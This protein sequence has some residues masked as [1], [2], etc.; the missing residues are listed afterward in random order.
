MTVLFI[1]TCIKYFV[2]C[3]NRFVYLLIS[4]RY[5]HWS[6]LN[7]ALYFNK[8]IQL[9]YS[10]QHRHRCINNIHI[11]IHPM[12]YFCWVHFTNF[13]HE[14]FSQTTEGV[15]TKSSIQYAP[16]RPTPFMKLRYLAY[17]YVYLEVTIEC[18]QNT[19]VHKVYEVTRFM[20]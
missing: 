11:Q 15:K 18:L 7:H 5:A 20:L 4:C 14:I 12:I 6:C 16:I 1:L 13:A 3:Y 9:F 10:V 19:A 8:C 2:T 17:Y